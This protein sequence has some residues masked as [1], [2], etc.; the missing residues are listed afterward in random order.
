MT[1]RRVEIRASNITLSGFN[2]GGTEVEVSFNNVTPKDCTFNDLGSGDGV[3]KS[4]S[5]SGLVVENCTFNGG[6]STGQVAFVNGGGGQ[7]TVIDNSFTNAPSHDVDIDSGV[8]ENNYF[9]GGRLRTQRPRRRNRGLNDIWRC[10]DQRKFHRLDK[11]H[12]GSDQQRHP[13]HDG[14]GDTSNVTVTNN[15]VVGGSWSIYAQPTASV[16]PSSIGPA[17]TWG[18]FSNV[19][20]S[21]NYVGFG[22][23]G[24]FYPGPGWR[25]AVEQDGV[26][27]HQ[28]GIL[29]QSLDHVSRAWCRDEITN[30]ID[31]QR[32]RRQP[33]WRHGALWRRHYGRSPWVEAIAAKQSLSVGPARS[34]KWAARAQISPN[35]SPFRIR[36][37]MEGQ[38]M[39]IIATRQRT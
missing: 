36:T 19:N 35:I 13:Y 23:Y 15:I 4:N 31:R 17:G 6:D 26:R 25:N 38:T 7:A 5:N 20:N 30:P 34:M 3:V 8:V 24:A 28:P 9:S 39:S 2:F 33:D 18:T 10:H 37:R 11:Q 29:N 21:N 12:L 27:L 1:P 14:R 16:V 22:Q 32:H